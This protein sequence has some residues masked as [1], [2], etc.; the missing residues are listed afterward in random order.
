MVVDTEP[1]PEAKNGK[2]QFTF[3]GEPKSELVVPDA[4]PTE[5]VG[6]VE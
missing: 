3:R 5:T 2:E 6:T 4:P 1:D